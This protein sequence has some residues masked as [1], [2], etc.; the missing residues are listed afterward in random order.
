MGESNLIPT[1]HVLHPKWSF[2]NHG[3]RKLLA[4]F[5]GSRSV[6]F[7]RFC[8][9][10]SLDFSPNAVSQYLLFSGLIKCRRN[11]FFYIFM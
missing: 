9:S 10:R 7:K 1:L 8:A 3:S 6:V 4:E 2:K 5:H 11:Y